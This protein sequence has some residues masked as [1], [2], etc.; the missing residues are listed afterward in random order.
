MN[1][2]DVTAS[3]YINIDT[4][5]EIAGMIDDEE[6]IAAIQEAPEEEEEETTST[7]ISHTVAL[8]SIQNLFNYLEQ[9]SDIKINNSTISGM[10]D[11]QHQIRRKQN[12][13]LK[14]PT[15]EAF[16]YNK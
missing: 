4:R 12:A 6:I 7:P 10:R 1:V 14:Q 9:N 13:S 5:I 3:N 15:L 8:D 11:L 2:D 16:F